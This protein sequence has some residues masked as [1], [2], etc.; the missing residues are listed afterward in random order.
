MLTCKELVARTS[1]YLDGQ[2]DLR[3]RLAVRSHL[4][5]CRHCRRFVRQMRLSQA[6][7]QRLEAPV[8]DDLDALASRL[9]N[10]RREGR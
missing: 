5:L 3:A 1:D 9:A 8:R 7:L 4:L 6:V 2:L 10:T